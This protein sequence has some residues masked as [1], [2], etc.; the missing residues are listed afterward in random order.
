MAVAFLLIAVI[1]WAVAIEKILVHSQA[2]DFHSVYAGADTIRRGGN[3]YLHAVLESTHDPPAYLLSF[4]PLTL[5]PEPLAE[6]L[7]NCVHAASLFLAVW[8]LCEVTPYRWQFAPVILLFPPVLS[9]F[10]LGQ[11]KLELL[12]L[13]ILTIR[14]AERRREG[15]AGAALALASLWRIFPI[16][17]LGYFAVRRNYRMLAWSIGWLCAGTLVTIALAGWTTCVDFLSVLHDFGEQG[18]LVNE[19]D[20]SITAMI[21]RGTGSKLVALTVMALILAAT[22]AASSGK[23]HHW[24]IYSL[25]VVTALLLLPVLWL[26]DLVF[27]LIPMASMTAAPVAAG[28]LILMVASYL[29]ASAPTWLYL[30]GKAILGARLSAHLYPFAVHAQWLSAVSGY[31]A[32]WLALRESSEAEAGEQPVPVL[33][34]EASGGPGESDQNSSTIAS[35]AETH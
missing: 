14:W 19:Y 35:R 25:W 16:V 32:V 21:L 2:A 31:A 24:R 30:F 28:A 6:I 7:W 29:F 15:L 3:P 18:I 23:E 34:S 9:N 11:L 27:M 20:F 13:L 8:L 17:L 12:C 5:L 4:A 10:D 22:V 26:Y 33:N 1:Y